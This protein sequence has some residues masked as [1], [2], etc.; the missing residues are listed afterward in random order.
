VSVA[1]ITR[2]AA[3]NAEQ[4]SAYIIAPLAVAVPPTDVDAI[5]ADAKIKLFIFSPNANSRMCRQNN[6][7][8]VT[9]GHNLLLGLQSQLKFLD[10]DK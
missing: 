8:P 6:C 10:F 2:G 5:N 9:S 3:A 7:F 4:L 1:A